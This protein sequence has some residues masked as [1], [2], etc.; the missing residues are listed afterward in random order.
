MSN[1]LS[2][3]AA[4]SSPSAKIHSAISLNWGTVNPLLARRAWELRNGIQRR[5]PDETC[6]VSDGGS[7]QRSLGDYKLQVAYTEFGFL[8][9][10]RMAMRVSPQ[11]SRRSSSSLC[12]GGAQPKCAS[13]SISIS[14]LP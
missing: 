1:S 8:R 9:Q 2:R 12:S 7:Q 4:L 14:P 3:T 5:F 10:L 6:H 11:S 13:W